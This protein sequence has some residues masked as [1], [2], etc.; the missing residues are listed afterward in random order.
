[1]QLKLA[2][3]LHRLG[4]ADLHARVVDDVAGL[5]G[6]PAVYH[7]D[8]LEN[9]AVG[10]RCRRSCLAARTAAAVG[11]AGALRARIFAVD[12]LLKMQP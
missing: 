6:P 2:M 3:G 1:M 8:R 9:K 4:K 7:F 5:C 11:S 12:V 10:R